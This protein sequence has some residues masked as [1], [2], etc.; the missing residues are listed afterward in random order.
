MAVLICGSVCNYPTAKHCESVRSGA[1]GKHTREKTR[2]TRGGRGGRGGEL[3]NERF[4]SGTHRR[5]HTRSGREK[6]KETTIAGAAMEPDRADM[7]GGGANGALNGRR[8]NRYSGQKYVKPY[9]KTTEPRA[10][11]RGKPHQPEKGTTNSAR[12]C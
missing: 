1:K 6:A 11:A 10:R 12:F 2:H 7:T 9:H 8:W 4:S 3:K 5:T